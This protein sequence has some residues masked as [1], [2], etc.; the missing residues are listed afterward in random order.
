MTDRTP[1][2]NQIDAQCAACNAAVPANAHLVDENI[3]GFIL[4]LSVHFQGFC[5]DLYTECTQIIAS[6]VRPTLQVLFQQQL[7]AHRSL[8]HGN[9]NIENLKKDFNRF[10]FSINIAAHNSANPARLD[11]LRELNKWRNIAA[12]HRV[13]P[14][15]GLPTHPSVQ[16]WRNSCNDLATSLDDIMCNHLRKIVKRQPWTP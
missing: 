4:L 1:R 10:G 8:D 11:G 12:H 15:A 2:L 9:P 16:G 3:R 5:R 14:P 6:K 7:T 13:V